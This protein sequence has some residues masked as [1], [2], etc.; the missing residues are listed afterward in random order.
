MPLVCQAPAFPS[1]S[2]DRSACRLPTEA[3]QTKS[4]TAASPTV[5]P[6]LSAAHSRPFSRSR[7]AKSSARVVR[8]HCC[9]S[10]PSWTL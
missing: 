6:E 3:A 4:S 8:L 7:T 2:A 9:R 10:N 5:E 1:A